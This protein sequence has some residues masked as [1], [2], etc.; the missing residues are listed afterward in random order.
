LVTACIKCQI[1]LRCAMQDQLLSD[2]IAIEIKDLA[3]LVAEAL[4]D[5]SKEL[6]V[7]SMDARSTASMNLC[8]SE[9]E[10]DVGSIQ[11]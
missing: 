10:Q 11:L 1:H 8:T 9:I 7:G 2:E 3:T 5:G 6:E 4:A